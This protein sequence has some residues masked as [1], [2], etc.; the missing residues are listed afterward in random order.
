MD[1]PFFVYLYANRLRNQTL[2][3]NATTKRY[4]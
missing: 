1:T 2:H 4:H 3:P